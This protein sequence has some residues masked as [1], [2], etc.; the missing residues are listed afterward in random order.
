MIVLYCTALQGSLLYC[1][2]GDWL[3]CTVCYYTSIYCTS[4]GST[5]LVYAACIYFYS[6]VGKVAI[7]KSVVLQL[8]L[9]NC[10]VLQVTILYGAV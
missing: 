1:S 6:T 9:L 4:G 3:V 5:V 10:I 2:A 7:N 8:P